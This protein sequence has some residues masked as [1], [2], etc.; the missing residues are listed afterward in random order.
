MNDTSVERA[1]DYHWTV[2]KQENHPDPS[3]QCY[4]DLERDYR[5]DRAWIDQMVAVEISGGVWNGGGHVRGSG[6]RRDYEKH[7]AAVL[8]GWRVLYCIPNMF[9]EDPDSFFSVLNHLLELPLYSHDREY[10]SWVSR[11]RNLRAV[12]EQI[13]H[14]G[15]QV[16]REKRNAFELHLSDKEY[17]TLP[18]KYLIDGQ[19]Q[20]LDLIL[21]G[22]SDS[23]TPISIRKWK[24]AKAQTALF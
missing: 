18:Q 23:T 4:F 7:N 5:F 10:H 19:K 17:H 14:N 21:H 22:K 1:F 16:I 12:G 15:I 24:R 3:P 6:L 9:E 8:I 13:D 20:A 2:C 11:I